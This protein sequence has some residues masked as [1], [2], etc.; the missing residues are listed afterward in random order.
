M[1]PTTA[2]LTS[3]GVGIAAH[4]QDSANKERPAT[5]ENSTG[6]QLVAV[7]AE[8]IWLLPGT[9]AVMD[10]GDR[11][12]IRENSAPA[13]SDDNSATVDSGAKAKDG[14]TALKVLAAEVQAWSAQRYPAP[15]VFTLHKPG[16]PQDRMLYCR[17]APAHMDA[18]DAVLAA[19]IAGPPSEAAEA[20]NSSNR[21]TI[22]GLQTQCAALTMKDVE[23]IIAR[24]P[25]TDQPSF[26]KY[27]INLVPGQ[28]GKLLGRV[29]LTVAEDGG[30]GSAPS[31][32][33]MDR[34]PISVYQPPSSSN[35]PKSAYSSS[36]ALPI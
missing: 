6:S 19:L 34:G 15:T 14:G 7:P 30:F 4:G 8:S 32:Q 23:A 31:S 13:F 33:K 9:I 11:I 22:S 12:V 16:T 2:A 21:A 5:E 27:L 35:T 20:R 25:F 10:C 1:R 18:P 26:A 17:L 29:P 3:T 24:A 36:D 28:A